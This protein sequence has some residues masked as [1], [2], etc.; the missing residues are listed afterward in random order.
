MNCSTPG[1]PILHYLPEFAHTGVH[2]VSN[3]IQS[4]HPLSPPSPLALN[5]SQHQALFLWVSSWHQVA[6]VLELSFSI[7]PFNEYSGLIFFRI[8]S[9]DLLSVQGTLKS[10]LQ[11]HSLRHYTCFSVSVLQCSA[12]STSNSHIST[13]LLEKPQLWLYR[14]LLA[15]WY[16]CFLIHFQVCHSFSSKEQASFNFVAAVT[17]HSDF[18]TQENEIW[19]CFPI[20]PF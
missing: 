1:F 12:F 20:F 19:H 13:W 18:G 3:V 17:I 7:S 6:K 5:L 16:L 9:F 15:K 8:D 4:S 11:H 10:L 2:C 14:P